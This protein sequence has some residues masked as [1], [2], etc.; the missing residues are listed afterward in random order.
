[1]DLTPDQLTNGCPENLVLRPPSRSHPPLVEVVLVHVSHR[2]LQL[3]TASANKLLEV[4]CSA[5]A[6]SMPALLH[7]VSCAETSF[8]TPGVQP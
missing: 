5:A 6:S 2:V 3:F 8:A 4:V 7:V 1:M